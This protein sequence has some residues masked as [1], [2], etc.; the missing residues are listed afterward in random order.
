MVQ[1]IVD[2]YILPPIANAASASL[3]LAPG[4]EALDVEVMPEHQ[5]VVE[6]A[7]L[8]GRSPVELPTRGNLDGWTGVVVQ[9]TEDGVEDG[10]EVAY[11]DADVRLAVQHFLASRASGA[12]EVVVLP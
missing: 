3:R 8:V 6:A 12:P 9:R 1:G 11:Q 4:G 10:H 7:R 2:T 5:G